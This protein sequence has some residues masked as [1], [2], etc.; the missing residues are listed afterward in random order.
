MTAALLIAL[1]A[2][3]LAA[4]A[5]PTEDPALGL[6]SGGDP[7]AVE[8]VLPVSRAL[9][10][11]RHENRLLFIKPVYGGMDREGALNYC[12]GTW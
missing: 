5:S 9:E 7:R 12:R 2:P 1:F 4:P 11:A 6:D 8:F 10:Q 3:A